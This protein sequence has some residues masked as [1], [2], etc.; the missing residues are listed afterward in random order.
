MNLLWIR[1]LSSSSTRRMPLRGSSWSASSSAGKSALADYL[2]DSLSA[3]RLVFDR[4][5][6]FYLLPLLVMPPFEKAPES[7]LFCGR[8]DR[9]YEDSPSFCFA[10]C[11]EAC[12][13]PRFEILGDGS[14]ETDKVCACI[15]AR[16]C[17]WS[18]PALDWIEMLS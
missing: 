15:P 11:L 3:R 16:S 2:G 5:V 18:P 17:R 8:N 12:L 1:S 13:D 14:L 7:S 10:F 4:M 9:F 6:T